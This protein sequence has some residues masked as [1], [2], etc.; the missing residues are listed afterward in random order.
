MKLIVLTISMLL[1]NFCVDCLRVFATLPQIIVETNDIIKS[2]LTKSEMN[3]AYP[4]FFFLTFQGAEF[5]VVNQKDY[6]IIGRIKGNIVN[7]I[8]K[9]NFIYI[10]Y[11]DN[12]ISIVKLETKWKQL[13]SV[14]K[15]EPQIG[16]NCF[17]VLDDEQYMLIANHGSILVISLHSK[18]N[19]YV[20]NQVGPT[21]K[22]ETAWISINY[23]YLVLANKGKNLG[24]F[25]FS[26]SIEQM[27]FLTQIS[28]K[29]SSY[30]TTFMNYNDKTYLYSYCKYLG[31]IT[32]DFTMLYNDKN[33]F[34]NMV[35]QYNDQKITINVMEMQ[36]TVNSFAVSHK[37]NQLFMSIRSN[38]I[39]I[40]EQQPN[41]LRFVQQILSNDLS[42]YVS[43]SDLDENFVLLADGINLKIF[44]SQQ[45][46]QLSEPNSLNVFNLNQNQILLQNFTMNQQTD[47][48]NIYYDSNKQLIFISNKTNIL[49]YQNEDIQQPYS[50]YRTLTEK[51]YTI[52]YFIYLKLGYFV[53]LR[54]PEKI[55]FYQINY[56][57]STTYPQ[58]NLSCPNCEFSSLSVSYDE[59]ILFVVTKYSILVYDLSSLSQI[60]K[61]NPKLLLNYSPEGLSSSA[62]LD[63]LKLH[64]SNKLGFYS[65][66]NYAIVF[67]N[68][69][70]DYQ[71]AEIQIVKQFLVQD[72]EYFDFDKRNFNYLIICSGTKGIIIFDCFGIENGQL[73]QFAH[74]VSI[75]GWTANFDQPGTKPNII[76]TN[77]SQGVQISVINIE[78]ILESAVE[79]QINISNDEIIYQ[80]IFFSQNSDGFL[81]LSTNK[82]FRYSTVTKPIILYYFLMKQS[83]INRIKTFNE[84]QVL[85]RSFQFDNSSYN[86]EVKENKLIIQVND[87]SEIRISPILSSSQIKFN[88]I[89][90]Y[91]NYEK[92]APPEWLTYQE[93]DLLIKIQPPKEV[94]NSNRGE[95][96]I[97]LQI[98]QSITPNYF[99]KV[100]YINSAQSQQIYQLLA[101]NSMI[102]QQGMFLNKNFYQFTYLEGD[103]KQILSN[104]SPT[105]LS[106][107]IDLIKF[108]YY[109]LQYQYP[110][111][112]KVIP[113]LSVNLFNQDKIE[114]LDAA[115]KVKIKI[116]SQASQSVKLF[117]ANSQ[118][119][120]Q[121]SNF[122]DFTGVFILGS[123]Q[124]INYYIDK[125]LFYGIPY[126]STIEDYDPQIRFE[127]QDSFN[128]PVTYATQ[129]INLQYINRIQPIVQQISLQS[130]YDEQ[131]SSGLTVQQDFSIQFLMNSFKNSNFIPISY[132]AYLLHDESNY[133]YQEQICTISCSYFNW[134]QFDAQNLKIYGQAGFIRFKK[135]YKVLI[136]AS[137]QFGS[138][139]D[140]FEIQFNNLPLS[141]IL[142]LVFLSLVILISLILIYFLRKRIH[143]I[144]AF[145][146]YTHSK[147]EVMVKQKYYKCIVCAPNILKSARIMFFLL[148]KD[149]FQNLNQNTKKK[150]KKQILNKQFAECYFNE[151]GNL[152][153]Q[154]LN[155]RLIHIFKVNKQKFPQIQLTNIIQSNSNF[156]IAIYSLL[157]QELLVN[158][159]AKQIYNYLKKEVRKSNKYLDWYKELLEIDEEKFIQDKKD[160]FES[161][162][163]MSER[164]FVAYPDIKLNRQKV[165]Q[166]IQDQKKIMTLFQDQKL[167]TIVENAL[168]SNY[169]GYDLSTQLKDWRNCIGE[170]LHTKADRIN[171][172]EIFEKIYNI[173][174]IK[175]ILCFPFIKERFYCNYKNICQNKI[176]NPDQKLPRWIQVLVTNNQILIKLSPKRASVGEYIITFK[177]SKGYTVYSFGV[178]LKFPKSPQ[179]TYHATNQN[180]NEFNQI[181]MKKQVQIS[182]EE[183][184]EDDDSHQE[185]KKKSQ[186]QIVIDLRK[187][188]QADSKNIDTQ[189]YL[190]TQN[191]Q[192][193]NSK[194]NLRLQSINL[195]QQNSLQNFRRGSIQ[196]VEQLQNVSL[197]NLE[198]IDY[199]Q[200]S[201]NE[202]NEGINTIQ[203]QKQFLGRDVRHKNP[204]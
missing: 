179:M 134:I 40:Y 92:I 132:K 60:N 158:S 64:W 29:N 127:A 104:L 50:N 22:V 85:L 77:Q 115:C 73:P 107:A 101:K 11:M 46:D 196:S 120:I 150:Q 192:S 168:K 44:C 118:D 16:I 63:Y 166:I 2:T 58:L 156:K 100:I 124:Q 197:I 7:A 151:Q 174:S 188:K 201:Q 108:S 111:Q 15:F 97:V 27:S 133:L 172:I 154:K 45:F 125:S 62:Y 164:Q 189:T 69:K 70:N 80:S 199:Y 96:T 191:N 6:S 153:N 37:Y 52:V 87:V 203:S 195:L 21:L 90:L 23:P 83:Q 4:N 162:Q 105:Q 1:L 59:S 193:P 38:G 10:Q 66:K 128:F 116:L 99:T 137:D 136:E 88:N 43:F 86:V 106:I 140:S 135:K 176:L 51:K 89:F 165:E 49:I 75:N 122:V 131:Y 78:N 102:D 198:K 12:Y 146:S 14:S 187:I 76:L 109:S 110:I 68:F 185:R 54:N 204:F 171:E 81:A 55:T 53:A 121:V 155:S 65:L 98:Y 93:K 123:Q 32:Y 47:R 178:L 17:D 138:I 139:S 173:S 67:F 200:T 184:V 41:N 103:I 117:G 161:K 159:D 157:S 30:I 84:Q 72:I 94:L 26:K 74:Q 13:S 119:T 112:L 34:I 126:N 182:E 149:F 142:I 19:P 35:K 160:I 181:E 48:G 177:N 167:V 186:N 169:Y 28:L 152:D 3:P 39:F 130:Q 5:A 175:Q 25:D 61:S 91:Q 9:T 129:L 148:K 141:L 113:S 24:V 36:G 170:T 180:N 42:N 194:F 71:T 56:Q 95:I 8:V 143:K 163:D 31:V 145:Y 79:Y 114:T 57:S 82:G 33:Q 183:S 147:I 144:T 20:I 190:Q 202:I 18:L